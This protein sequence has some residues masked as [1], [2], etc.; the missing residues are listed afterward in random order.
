[1]QNI[2][3]YPYII[4]FLQIMKDETTKATQKL[5]KIVYCGVTL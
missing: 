3:H 1:M 5:L 4:G 2:I